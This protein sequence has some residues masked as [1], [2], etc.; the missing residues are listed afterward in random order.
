MLGV[1]VGQNPLRNFFSFILTFI[2][3]TFITRNIFWLT[4]SVSHSLT[5]SL[6]HSLAH[7]PTHS[8]T[9]AL[10][11]SLTHSCFISL[12]KTMK[13]TWKLVTTMVVKVSRCL[14]KL[15]MFTIQAAHTI[16][17]SSASLNPKII[18]ATKK[19]GWLYFENK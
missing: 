2:Q 6:T 17:L 5:Q 4:H 3:C 19:L 16:P 15:L 11:H 13:Y 7:S 1:K 8:P 9:H 10:T 12:F 18:A 14:I